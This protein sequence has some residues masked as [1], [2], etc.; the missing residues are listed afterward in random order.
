MDWFDVTPR[1]GKYE[2]Q[3]Y[4]WGGLYRHRLRDAPDATWR[5]GRPSEADVKHSRLVGRRPMPFIEGKELDR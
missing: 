1:Y 4:L 5:D 3:V 2:V